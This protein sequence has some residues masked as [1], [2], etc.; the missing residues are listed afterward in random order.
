MRK[1]ITT[2]IILV[3]VSL[4]GSALPWGYMTHFR[5]GDDLT[6]SLPSEIDFNVFIRANACSDLAWTPFFSL[7]DRTYIHTPEFAE[8]L[9]EVASLKPQY[10]NWLATAYGW[11]IHLAF[12]G[13]AHSLFVPENLILHSL[14]E[15]AVDTCIYYEGSPSGWKPL[16]SYH[17][18]WD[19]C[20]PWLISE[21]SRLYQED[22]DPE[23]RLIRPWMVIKALATLNTMIVNE[24]KYIQAKGGPET[25]ELF[26]N[27]LV[28][29][30]ILPGSWEDYYSASLDAALMWIDVHSSGDHPAPIPTPI[31][32]TIVLL[33]SSLL[34]L[35]GYHQ[36][37]KKSG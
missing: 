6:A 33:G 22:Y 37:W 20:N 3:V 13:V 15:S 29:K 2:L 10:P 7:S 1:Y 12:D 25:S 14:V 27:Y 34:G 21:A 4:P 19:C 26:L 17:L 18:G 24:Y 31:P 23:A 30:G 32:S 16:P 5:G 11:G 28:S 35:A 8:C 36:I 9:F